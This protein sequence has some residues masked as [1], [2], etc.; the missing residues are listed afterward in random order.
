MTTERRISAIE[1]ALTPTELIVAWLTEAHAHGG[2]DAMVR[3]SLAYENFVPPINR[4]GRAASEGARL[5]MKGRP[6]DEIDRA[7][8]RA[9][10]QAV[11][12]TLFRFHLVIR[13]NVV[14]H[15]LLERELVG[16]AIAGVAATHA[17][18]GV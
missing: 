5:R 8:D 13:I 2:V 3:A 17:V 16:V 18:N 15:D 6:R 11:R 14:C 4:L 12:E 9:S 7:S 1:G 10:D